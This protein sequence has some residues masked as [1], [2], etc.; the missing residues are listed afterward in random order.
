MPNHL[1]QM[2]VTHVLSF[3]RLQ[4]VHVSMDTYSRIL[5]ASAHSG[6]KVHDVKSHCIMAFAYMG[7]SKKN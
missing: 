7:G 3:G 6:E 2:D 4:F 1:W 5:F